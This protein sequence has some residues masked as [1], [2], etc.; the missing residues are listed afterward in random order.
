MKWHGCAL[1]VLIVWSI[2]SIGLGRVRAQHLDVLVQQ[3]NGKLVT[4]SADFDTGQWTIGRRVFS[5]EFDSDFAVNSPGYNALAAGSPS[6]PTGS[7]ALP[8]SAA[9]SWDFL[10]MT[11]HQLQANLFYWNGL[12]SDNAPGLT[13]NDVVFGAL[14]GPNYGLTLFDKSGSGFV[15]NG[16][17]AVV[18]G[19][20]VDDTAADGS[21][22]RH[23]FYLLQDGDGNG[24]TLPVDGIYLFSMQMRVNGLTSADPLFMVFGTP[25]S[26]VAALDSAAVPWV[27]QHL[28]VPGDYNGNGAVD[29]ADYIAWRNGAPLQ[30]EIATPNTSTE[31]DVTEWRI[32]FGNPAVGGASGLATVQSVPEPPVWAFPLV[33]VTGR[34]VCRIRKISREI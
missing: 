12:E 9:L 22:H 14:P 11:I 8:G 10:P 19:G 23:R 26:S 28:I 30:N 2:L 25:G 20:V 5:G 31:E 13:P 3:A 18:P 15:V 29:A 16:A 21:L 6:L 1:V 34:F 24:S 7:Q 27:E 17:N 33:L 4:G 32:R